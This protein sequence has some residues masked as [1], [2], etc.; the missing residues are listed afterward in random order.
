MYNNYINCALLQLHING[1]VQDCSISIANAL[2]IL[3][4]CTEPSIHPVR[5]K[6]KEYTFY[7]EESFFYDDHIDDW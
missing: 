2:E 1:L 6:T 4:S 7:G 5:Y 3:Q